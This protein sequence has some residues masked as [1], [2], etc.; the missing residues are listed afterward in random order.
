[1]PREADFREPSDRC[2]VATGPNIRGLREHREMAAQDALT[3]GR[4]AFDRESWA[5]V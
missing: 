4:A 3:L 1:M 2:T 5:D